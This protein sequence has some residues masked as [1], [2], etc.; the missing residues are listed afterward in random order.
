MY[1]PKTARFLQEDT[2]RGD[3]ND[4]L[5]LNLYTYC[6]NEPIMYDD[7]TGHN[8]N[9][10]WAP[11]QVSSSDV[12]KAVQIKQ[13][14]QEKQKVETYKK[15]AQQTPAVVQIGTK[16]ATAPD[17]KDYKEAKKIKEQVNKNQAKEKETNKVANKATGNSSLP[18]TV[19]SVSN[20]VGVTSRV[21]KTTV[22]VSF[23]P[24]DSIIK[25]IVTIGDGIIDALPNTNETSKPLK[26]INKA[27]ELGG[28]EAKF[29]SGSVLS[30]GTL[31]NLQV[32]GKVAKGT[33][34]VGTALT[35]FTELQTSMNMYKDDL[36]LVAQ[37]DPKNYNKALVVATVGSTA[38]AASFGFGRSIANTIPSLVQ[39]LPGKDPQWTQGWIDTVNANVNAKRIFIGK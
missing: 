35:P 8:K 36:A 25:R 26:L 39:L 30:L 28:K 12:K 23:N 2:Y 33:G 20:T 11:Y 5:S 1:D 13:Q 22:N 17:Y 7:P 16:K 3:P 4:P 6:N 34:I 38:D 37:Y 32:V 10:V 9:P 27:V 21:G 15:L 29:S 31:K 18:S 14:M 24:G 19:S